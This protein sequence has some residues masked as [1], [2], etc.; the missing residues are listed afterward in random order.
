VRR[1]FSNLGTLTVPS[2]AYIVYQGASTVSPYSARFCRHASQSSKRNHQKTN[3]LRKSKPDCDQKS[4][5][6]SLFQKILRV[7]PFASIFWRDSHRYDSR[8]I[9]EMKILQNT[10]KKCGG[11]VPQG[12]EK[13][14]PRE[15]AFLSTRLSL[16]DTNPQN[17]DFVTL[18]EAGRAGSGI[19]ECARPGRGLGCLL[20]SLPCGPL[21]RGT[22]LRWKRVRQ[23]RQAAPD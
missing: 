13:G 21:L 5:A 20:V 3:T 22:R 9:N 16:L 18:W 12:N 4:A 23:F 1:K 10:K 7:S 19:G 17:L 14:G 15:A 6:N 11:G 8:N 2:F